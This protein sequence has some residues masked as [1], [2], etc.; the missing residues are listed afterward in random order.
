M[1]FCVQR[2]LYNDSAV[3]IYEILLF[4]LQ[5]AYR[6]SKEELSLCR[7]LP[8]KKLAQRWLR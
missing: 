3:Y 6:G 4:V 8:T 2:K 7:V 5:Q 1:R